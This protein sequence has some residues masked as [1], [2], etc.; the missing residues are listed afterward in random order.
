MRPSPRFA[1][2]RV[3]A[4]RSFLETRERELSSSWSHRDSA[5]AG[6]SQLLHA[7]L[8]T[9]FSPIL[10]FSVDGARKEPILVS[11]IFHRL[12]QLFDAFF[13]LIPIGKLLADVVDGDIS[14]AVVEATPGMS[15]RARFHSALEDVLFVIASLQLLFSLIDAVFHILFV[16]LLTDLLDRRLAT[17]RERQSTQHQQQ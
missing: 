6:K 9:A 7:E 14:L 8:K 1:G 13:H 5:L 2:A 3:R 15:G 12:A 4:D 16:V 10:V 11:A 17:T